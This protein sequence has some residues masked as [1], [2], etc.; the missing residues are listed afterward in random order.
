MRQKES[1]N[2]NHINAHEQLIENLRQEEKIT[3]KSLRHHN[4]WLNRMQDKTAEIDQL[5]LTKKEFFKFKDLIQIEQDLLKESSE[6]H[7]NHFAMVENFVEKYVPIGCQSQ[8][9]ETLRFLLK[10]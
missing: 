9:S 6:L 10:D 7:E 8:I 1:N 4:D 2:N 5:K 3:I